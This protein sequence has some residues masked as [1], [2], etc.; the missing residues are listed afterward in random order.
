MSS[1]QNSMTKSENL[2]ADLARLKAH[3][4]HKVRK[5]HKG[6]KVIKGSKVLKGIQGN[7]VHEVR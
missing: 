4:V 2:K 1:K 6:F 5:A 7:K 3:K